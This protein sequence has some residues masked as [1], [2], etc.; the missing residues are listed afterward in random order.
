MGVSG[1]GKATLVN[2]LTQRLPTGQVQGELSMDGRPVPVS[3]KR[4]IA[5]AQQQ[6]VHLETSP[7]AEALQ[8]S[9]M[10]GQQVG[11]PKSE[12]LAW[13]EDTISRLVM[14]DYAEAVV[15]VPGKGLSIEQRK[16]FIINVE[17]AAS[18]QSSCSWTSPPPVW[19]ARLPKPS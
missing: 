1:A 2:A 19:I 18:L 7:L 4:E 14:Q 13:F 12:K 9:A 6:D 11:V 15:G 10:L 3:F 17:L 8:F 5:Y 16:R